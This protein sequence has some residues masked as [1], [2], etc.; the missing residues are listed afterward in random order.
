MK[1]LLASIMKGNMLSSKIVINGQEITNE[2]GE[3]AKNVKIYAECDGQILNLSSDIHIEV[4]GDCQEVTTTNGDVVVHGNAEDV[5]TTNGE[6]FVQGSAK[7]VRTTNGNVRA[8]SIENANT[9]NGDI[10]V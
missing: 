10:K 1:Q 7:K 9:V 4:K 8:S 5:S 2:F 6:V 3:A